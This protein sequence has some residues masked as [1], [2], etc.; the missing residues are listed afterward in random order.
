M[1]KSQD[2]SAS[3]DHKAKLTIMTGA[4]LIVTAIMLGA[5]GAHGLRSKVS[6]KALR[7]FQTGVDY[8]MYHGLGF[9]FLGFVKNFL[10]DKIVLRVSFIFLC[11][12]VAFFSLNCYLYAVTGLKNFAMFVPIGGVSFIIGWIIFIF[13]IWKAPTHAR[14]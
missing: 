1:E 4:G 12:G 3:L 14:D 5:F 6:E 7:T 2:F 10:R 9:I 11:L 13:K 8:Q